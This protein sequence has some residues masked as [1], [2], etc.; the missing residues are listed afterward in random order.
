MHIIVC[1]TRH[2]V[3]VSILPLDGYCTGKGNV[4]THR[5]LAYGTQK[6]QGRR[7]NA[8]DDLL[9]VSKAFD[10]VRVNTTDIHIHIHNTIVQFSPHVYMAIAD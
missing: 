9:T 3:L 1:L 5:H 6:L 8:V 7:Q 4:L 10:S 2:L